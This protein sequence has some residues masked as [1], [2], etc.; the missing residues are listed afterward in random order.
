MIF[1]AE[2]P[3]QV[4]YGY[5]PLG[6]GVVVFGY[7]LWKLFNIILNDRNKA[8]EDRE[9]MVQDVFTKVLPAIARNTEVLLARQEIDR[10]LTDAI[11]ESNKQLQE[12]AEAF[13]EVVYVLRHTQ[14][15]TRVGGP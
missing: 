13:K 1:M 3:E 7:I 12:D 2:T 5:G 15:N 6:I 8:F 10:Q 14:G 11:K 4:L 9:A